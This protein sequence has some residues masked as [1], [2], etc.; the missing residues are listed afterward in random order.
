MF[1]SGKFMV[2]ITAKT[3]STVL[4]KTLLQNLFRCLSDSFF[5]LISLMAADFEIK[6]KNLKTFVERFERI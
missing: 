2:A 1:W 4:F 3:R 6:T 5:I